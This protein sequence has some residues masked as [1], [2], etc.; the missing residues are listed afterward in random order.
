MFVHE[1]YGKKNI[2]L[3]KETIMLQTPT[4]HKS[5]HT[6]LCGMYSLVREELDMWAMN[7][8]TNDQ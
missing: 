5:D 2:I 1:K 4:D 8:P 6:F 3:N 7:A